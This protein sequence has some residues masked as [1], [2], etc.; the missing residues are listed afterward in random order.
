MVTTAETTTTIEDAGTGRQFHPPKPRPTS[1]QIVQSDV[2]RELKHKLNFKS[3]LPTHFE[4]GSMMKGNG[5]AE[6]GMSG[7]FNLHYGC[8][9][10]SNGK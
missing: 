2:L 6:D 8:F 3:E 10:S 9:N 7:Q 5:Q 1:F 4:L